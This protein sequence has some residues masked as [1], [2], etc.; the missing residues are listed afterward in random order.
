MVQQLPLAPLLLRRWPLLPLLLPL[1]QPTPASCLCAGGCSAAT[2]LL[3][4]PLVSGSGRLRLDHREV[5][6]SGLL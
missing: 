1:V 6:H 4:P 5:K 3:L 2:L